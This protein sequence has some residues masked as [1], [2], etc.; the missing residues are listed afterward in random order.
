[1]QIRLD[2]TPGQIFDKISRST[3]SNLW[4][5]PVQQTRT[6]IAGKAR[7]FSTPGHGGYVVALTEAELSAFPL[8]GDEIYSPIHGIH[9]VAFEEDCAWALPVLF[10]PGFAEALKPEGGK[11]KLELIVEAWDIYNRWL[12]PERDRRDIQAANVLIAKRHQ[13]F[14]EKTMANEIDEPIGT[15]VVASGKPTLQVGVIHSIPNVPFEIIDSELS[16]L[17]PFTTVTLENCGE[18][19][20]AC[21]ARWERAQSPYDPAIAEYENTVRD[22]GIASR[23]ADRLLPAYRAAK[24]SS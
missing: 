7:W 11:A 16:K 19:V 9:Y 20:E 8:K 15:F 13:L 18:F 12:D 6:V 22:N 10:L 17:P 21:K 2:A 5:S 4:G 24:E 14:E 3:A 1:M 23:E